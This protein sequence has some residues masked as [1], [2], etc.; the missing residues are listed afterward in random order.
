MAP[1]RAPYPY[2]LPYVFD[3]VTTL[4]GRGDEIPIHADFSSKGCQK[5]ALWCVETHDNLELSVVLIQREND[6]ETEKFHSIMV[7]KFGN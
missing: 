4:V 7:E 3:G 2:D 1:Y 5:A 6:F